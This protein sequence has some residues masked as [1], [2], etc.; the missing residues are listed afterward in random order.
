M[1]AVDDDDDGMPVIKP[2]SKADQSN[3]NNEHQRQFISSMCPKL[4]QVSVTEAGYLSATCYANILIVCFSQLM[5]ER[6]NLE[7]PMLLV[8]RDIVQ[9]TQLSQSTHS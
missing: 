6:Y 2:V 8:N 5:I 3:K 4:W 7:E 1:L 9:S